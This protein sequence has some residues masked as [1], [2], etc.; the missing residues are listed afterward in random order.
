MCTWEAADDLSTWVT[1]FYMRGMDGAPGIWLYHGP[2]LPIVGI[3][4][5]NKQVEGLALSPLFFSLFLP[6]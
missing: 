4:E 5:E 3:W 6:F 2:V 1:I